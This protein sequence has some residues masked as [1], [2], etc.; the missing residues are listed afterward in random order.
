MSQNQVT[1]IEQDSAAAI[2]AAARVFDGS[3][4][5]SPGLWVGKPDVQGG[6]QQEIWGLSRQIPEQSFYLSWHHNA[7]SRV[8]L[9]GVVI[10]D[11]HPR[12]IKADAGG[13]DAVVRELVGGFAGGPANAAMLLARAV[14]HIAAIGETY[15]VVQGEAKKADVKVY[16]PGDEIQHDETV[17]WKVEDDDG[18]WTPVGLGLVIRAWEGDPQK[19]RLAWSPLRAALTVLRELAALTQLVGAEADSRLSA[20]LLLWPQSYV[21][22][23]GVKAF[24]NELIEQLSAPITDRAS[25]AS[26]VPL[27]I[28]MPDEAIDKVRHIRMGMELSHQAKELR[29]ESIRRFAM[30]AR[31][32]PEILTGT[33]DISHWGQWFID[34]QGI[35][36]FIAPE[37]HIVVNSWSVGWLQGAL[38]A[39][40]WDEERRGQYAIWPDFTPLVLRPDRSSDAVSLY[41]RLLLSGAAVLRETGFDEN[42]APTDEEKLQQL[43]V[44]VARAAPSSILD[45]LPLLPG[46]PP[47]L[48]TLAQQTQLKGREGKP[49]VGGPT[50]APGQGSKGQPVVDNVQPVPT[51]S[52][53][54]VA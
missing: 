24:T 1:V 14:N 50:A 34:E 13:D 52:A 16:C 7:A 37:V 36:L 25:A 18:V 21:P 33:G 22:M 40:G 4:K 53:K 11:G 27:P 51:D 39:L 6:W 23:G 45:L 42:D 9:R 43:V 47:E 20:G 12:E 28:P 32:P 48:L 5:K 35:K 26:V 19:Q 46:V 17:G 2:I 29:D 44:S 41:D 38:E 31:I 15:T 54:P 49:A 3:S 8:R 30:G 10:E